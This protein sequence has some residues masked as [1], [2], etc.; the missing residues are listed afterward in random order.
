MSLRHQ[1]PNIPVPEPTPA[2]CRGT[3]RKADEAFHEDEG[4]EPAP[5]RT[6]RLTDSEPAPLTGSWGIMQ[7]PNMTDSTPVPEP[8]EITPAEHRGTKRKADEDEP[9]P[10]RIAD[11]EPAPEP[12]E[13]TPA[14]EAVP[15]PSGRIRH[16]LGVTPDERFPSRYEV[17]QEQ[18][19]GVGNDSKVFSAIRRSD[20]RQPGVPTPVFREI[21][22]M[23]EM[24]K[25]PP[26]S[27]C[28]IQMLDWFE[29]LDGYIVVLE[30][31]AEPWLVQAIGHC[32]QRMVKHPSI[33]PEHIMINTETLELKL[34]GFG[35]SQHILQSVEDHVIQCRNLYS[36]CLYSYERPVEHL[37]NHPW[38][39]NDEWTYTDDEPDSVDEIER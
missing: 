4:T 27:P 29:C 37:P 3:K 5:Q 36:M 14:D 34:V 31:L 25:V 38:M 8:M 15:G 17:F 22:M 30:R 16:G 2:E 7:T 6:R 9:T 10:N 20:G 21:V 32:L 1:T 39:T 26:P 23:L 13:I 12:I 35:E 28:V 11:S 18:L 33:I 24:Q 19:L